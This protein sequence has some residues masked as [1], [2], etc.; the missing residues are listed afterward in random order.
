MSE[1]N[2]NEINQSVETNSTLKKSPKYVAAIAWLSLMTQVQA[3]QVLE[4]VK[5]PLLENNKS[6]LVID[7]CERNINTDVISIQNFDGKQ[8]AKTLERDEQ[9]ELTQYNL[10]DLSIVSNYDFEDKMYLH[11]EQT[12]TVTEN[13]PGSFSNI[14]DV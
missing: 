10:S 7:N 11:W 1:K 14:Y 6:S 8:I 3:Q 5:N 2:I 4:E 9:P 13:H 12:T